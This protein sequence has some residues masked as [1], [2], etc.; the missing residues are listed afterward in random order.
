MKEQISNLKEALLQ[1]T[2]LIN[3]INKANNNHNND[4]TEDTHSKKR[5]KNNNNGV[6]KDN[7]IDEK[8]EEE[9]KI[10]SK[11]ESSK[12]SL[13]HTRVIPDARPPQCLNYVYPADISSKVSVN[14]KQHVNPSCSPL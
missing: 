14:I 1:S 10:D 2:E 9:K 13:F 3:N 6:D 12:L 11:Q 5:L 8:L 4:N 7:N